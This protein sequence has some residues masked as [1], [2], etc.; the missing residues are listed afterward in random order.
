MKPHQYKTI[1]DYI[2]SFPVDIQDVLQQ[3]RASIKHAIPSVEEN[4]KYNMPVLIMNGKVLYFAAFRHHI[5]LY[6]RFR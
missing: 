1:D 6:W 3:I 5:G 2:S 4:I